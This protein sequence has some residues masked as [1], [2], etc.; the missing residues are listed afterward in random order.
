MHD[1]RR[2]KNQHGSALITALFI[3]TLVAIA[4]TAM[5]TRLQLDIYR[6]RTSIDSDKRYLASQAVTGWAMTQLSGKKAP[7]KAL[8]KTGKLLEFPQKLHHIYPGIVL[9]GSLLDCQAKFNINNL[10]DK[11]NLQ[12][13]KYQMLFYNLI[14][15]TDGTIP[16]TQRK[17]IVDTT[18][19]WIGRY[20][21][22]RGHDEFMDFYLKQKP[23]YYPGYQLMQNVS[24][25]RLV[26][27]VT[28]ALYQAMLP[29]ITALPE[30]VAIN[31][32]T[33]SKSI[34]MALG[35]GL[36]ESQV[37]EL[38]EARGQK[39]INNMTKITPLLKTLT[40]PLEQITL[41]S[42]YF[43]SMATATLDDSRLTVYTVIKRVKN[44]KN[45]VLLSIV[46]ESLN[47][48]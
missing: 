17:L 7:F 21:P 43:L 36:N 6:T 35:N 24:E 2:Q 37:N 48:P 11:N 46:R 38:L 1:N 14:G 8:D 34:L 19:H 32:N 16:A 42:S 15:N 18:T 13:K 39:G 30:A 23:P 5:S 3:M 10:Q 28:P 22:E 45:E 44:N 9:E 4:A 29:S 20:Q 40:I 41:E 47:V 27:G 31:I 12:N 33:A 26:Y 25:F